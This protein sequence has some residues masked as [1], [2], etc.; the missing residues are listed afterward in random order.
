[1][2]ETIWFGIK[3]GIGLMIGIVLVKAIIIFFVIAF[4]WLASYFDK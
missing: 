3:I 4:A 2:I 1:M